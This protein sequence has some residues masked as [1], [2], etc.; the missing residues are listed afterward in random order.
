MDSAKDVELPEMLN[1][2]LNL[3]RDCTGPRAQICTFPNHHG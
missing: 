1:L 2:S 3:R